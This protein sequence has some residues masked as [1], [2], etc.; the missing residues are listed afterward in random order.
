M[1]AKKARQPLIRL[2]G[3]QTTYT[4]P[5]QPPCS[6]PRTGANLESSRSGPTAA[7]FP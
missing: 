4:E 2:N 6:D 7:T 5:Q 1:L 3:N